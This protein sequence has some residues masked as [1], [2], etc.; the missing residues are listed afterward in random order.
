MVVVAAAACLLTL[1]CDGVRAEQAHTHTAAL[2]ELTV[3]AR[4]RPHACDFGVCVYACSV[5][6]LVVGTPTTTTS[7]GEVPHHMMV[8][9]RH[10]IEPCILYHIHIIHMHG[11]AI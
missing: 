9:P 4:R 8:L 10:S 2:A 7:Y 5:V 11:C 1:V 3:V 6:V